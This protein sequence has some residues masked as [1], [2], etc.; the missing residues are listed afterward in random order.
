MRLPPEARDLAPLRLLGPHW[1]PRLRL[2]V[3]TLPLKQ[4]ACDTAG[5]GAAAGSRGACPLQH[6]PSTTYLSGISNAKWVLCRNAVVQSGQV[7]I[8]S[9][10][11][12]LDSLIEKMSL[13]SLT[14][15]NPGAGL[16]LGKLCSWTTR[17][18]PCLH[19]GRSKTLLAFS[20]PIFVMSSLVPT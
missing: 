12:H 2:S 20:V 13:M 14:R 17:H 16:L 6:L 4:P 5:S 3:V 15:L 1:T 9:Q 19:A 11:V 7:H 10:A 18:L 8:L